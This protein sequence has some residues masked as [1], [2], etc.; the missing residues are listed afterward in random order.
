MRTARR[1]LSWSQEEI[2]GPF[3][4]R[5]TYHSTSSQGQYLLPHTIGSQALKSETS[6]CVPREEEFTPGCGWNRQVKF[7]FSRRTSRTRYTF[8]SRGQTE[9]RVTSK[10]PLV[11]VLASAPNSKWTENQQEDA[12]SAE[13]QSKSGSVNLGCVRKAAEQASK[14]GSYGVSVSRLNFYNLSYLGD[15]GKK[16]SGVRVLGPDQR[17]AVSNH[18]GVLPHGWSLPA[19]SPICSY[20][21]LS[22]SCPAGA[23]K[24]S[25][26]K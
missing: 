26:T 21:F 17:E 5:L 1:P 8:W 16:I 3:N 9:S 13:E 6:S 22:A 20:T 7:A 24:S 18:R 11:L 14:Q 19:H 2:K 25:P 12:T 23:E 10:R 15:W 4:Q